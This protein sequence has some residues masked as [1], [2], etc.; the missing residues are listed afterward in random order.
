MV[1]F[2]LRHFYPLRIR[3]SNNNFHNSSE[4]QV[5]IK[6]NLHVQDAKTIWIFI[7]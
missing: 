4:E 1:P 7:F 6:S 3:L 2:D 5:Q